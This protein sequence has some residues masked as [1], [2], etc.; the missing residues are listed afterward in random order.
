MILSASRRTDISCHYSDWFM[1]RL[2]AGYVLMR[3][4]MNHELEFEM[5]LEGIL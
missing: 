2:T 5:K 3:N 4:P 1:N